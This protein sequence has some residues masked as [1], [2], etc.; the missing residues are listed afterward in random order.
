VCAGQSA[1]GVDFEIFIALIL[2]P[3]SY[4]W[5]TY[6]R[7]EKQGKLSAATRDA[8]TIGDLA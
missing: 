8:S 7:L 2:N 5:M 4:S 6:K 1:T 3:V